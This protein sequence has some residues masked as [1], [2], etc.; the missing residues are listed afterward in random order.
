MGPVLECGFNE[1]NCFGVDIFPLRVNLDPS[2]SNNPF[3]IYPEFNDVF[4]RRHLSN[5]LDVGGDVL[6]VFGRVAMNE[7]LNSGRTI[8]K[9]DLGVENSHLRIYIEMLGVYFPSYCR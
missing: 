9:L 4:L 2:L 6:L 8:K 5:F 3:E 1:Q 7:I